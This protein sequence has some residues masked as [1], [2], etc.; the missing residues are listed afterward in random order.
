MKLKEGAVSH[1]NYLTTN[2][3]QQNTFER[4]KENQKGW[5]EGRYK[6]L[7]VKR[8]AFRI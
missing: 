5:L 8:Q 7:N 3:K 4:N 1:S 2:T 6:L